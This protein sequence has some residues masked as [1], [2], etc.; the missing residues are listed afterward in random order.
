VDR[1]THHITACFREFSCDSKADPAR[2]P[3]H[4]RTLPLE[5]HRDPKALTTT[6]R[7]LV[8]VMVPARVHALR[9]QRETIPAARGLTR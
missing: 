1:A 2:R 8:T 4:Q 3:R 7:F 9:F 5:T 6:S